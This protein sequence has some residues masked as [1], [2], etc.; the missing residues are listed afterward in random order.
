MLFQLIKGLAAK[1][2]ST[3]RPSV[4]CMAFDGSDLAHVPKH[5]CCLIVN[6]SEC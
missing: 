6:E 4:L 1:P 3:S 2:L 5:L